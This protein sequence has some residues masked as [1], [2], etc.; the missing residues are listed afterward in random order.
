MV[1]ILCDSWDSGVNCMKSAWFARNLSKTKL[2]FE[3]F[4]HNF[5]DEE[6]NVYGLSRTIFYLKDLGLFAVRLPSLSQGNGLG[7]WH[8]FWYFYPCFAQVYI[9]L[10]IIMT[11]FIKQDIHGGD[12]QDGYNVVAEKIKK[13]FYK[14]MLLKVDHYKFCLNHLEKTPWSMGIS[15]WVTHKCSNSSEVNHYSP[16]G[17][18]LLGWGWHASSII[19]FCIS[20]LPWPGIRGK[21][22]AIRWSLT[23]CYSAIRRHFTITSYQ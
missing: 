22:C 6:I 10:L 20:I 14:S 16:G 3:N 18:L 2:E 15:G 9:F 12:L 7:L 19:S 23:A 5:K 21:W 17:R 4:A 13:Q 8:N 1:W 11:I